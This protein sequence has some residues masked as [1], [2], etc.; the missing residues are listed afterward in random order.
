MFLNRNVFR[1]WGRGVVT[2]LIKADTSGTIEATQV[3][4]ELL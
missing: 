3:H 4:D 2:A 1:I